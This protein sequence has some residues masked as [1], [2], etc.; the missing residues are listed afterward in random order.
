M[1]K[2]AAHQRPVRPSSVPA[3]SAIDSSSIS[4]A[5]TISV[6]EKSRARLA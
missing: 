2:A 4:P 5:T 3:C 1:P 6:H